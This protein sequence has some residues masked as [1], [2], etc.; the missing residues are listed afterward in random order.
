MSDS[1]SLIESLLYQCEGTAID[2][3][4]KQYLFDKATEDQK[5]EL[6]KDVLAFANSWRQSDAYIVIGVKAVIGGRHN[7][8]DIVEHF[9]DAQLQQFINSKINRPIEMIYEVH[10]YEGNRIGVIKIAKQERPFY[11]IKDYGKV[12]KGLVYYRLGS[13]TAIASPD[14]I[15]RMGR[16]IVPGVLLPNMSLQFAD[17]ATRKELGREIRLRSVIF[18]QPLQ[19]IPRME[20][21]K[22]MLGKFVMPS[23]LHEQVNPEYWREKE[24]FIRLRGLLQPVALVIQNQSSILA[25]QVRVEIKGSLADGIHVTDEL[26]DEPAYYHV[27]MV[28]RIRP[29]WQKQQSML[30]VKSYVDQWSVTLRFGDVQPKSSVWLDQPFY[31]GSMNLEHLELDAL[32]FANNLPEPQK[33]KLLIEFMIT[34]KPGLTVSELY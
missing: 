26:P 7:P 5:S 11:A 9:D 31:L 12:K 27:D 13:S 34:K 3:K 16:E 14:D 28:S 8:L 33:V 4:S 20:Q 17:H 19:P 25:E 2:F 15:A 23:S 24:V 6:L 29:F 18:S 10:C 22:T 32:I 21:P 1:S 30:E